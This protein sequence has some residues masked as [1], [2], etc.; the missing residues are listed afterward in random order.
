MESNNANQELD[1]PVSE[2]SLDVI[3]TD[4][5]DELATANSDNAIDDAVAEN[6]EIMSDN[7]AAESIVAVDAADN[8]VDDIDQ[9]DIQYE[10]IDEQLGS[11]TFDKPA[12]QTVSNNT[13]D[14]ASPMTQ[15]TPIT[16]PEAVTGSFDEW[17]IEPTQAWPP[18][19]FIRKNAT[20]RERFYLEYRWHSQWSF[21]DSKASQNKNTYYWYQRIIVIGALMIPALI[22]LNSTIARFITQVFTAGGSDSET[23]VRIGIDSF[24]VFVSLAVAGAAALESLYKYGE[25][26]SSYRSA[27]EELQA[28]KNF[29]DMS[30][31]PYENNPTA[32]ATFVARIEGIIANQNGKYFQAVQQQIAKQTEDNDAI[33]DRFLADDEDDFDSPSYAS[34]S[35]SIPDIG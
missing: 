27:A 12:E 2:D 19:M 1:Q 17:V 34:Q 30:A 10:V 25:N 14:K 35:A 32:F 16:P 24:T 4:A 23:I 3:S 26:W 29:Y 13:Y 31:G 8:E 9:T 7:S 11:N 15:P 6:S 18:P 33:V 28:E 21:Y 20:P 22:S 5:S